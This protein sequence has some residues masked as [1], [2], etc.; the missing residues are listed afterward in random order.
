[1]RAVLL[2]AV[3]FIAVPDREDP[4]AKDAKTLAK[5]LLGAW[6]SVKLTNFGEELDLKLTLVFESDEVRVYHDGKYQADEDARYVID[7][8]KMPAT[9]DI[10]P[11]KPCQKKEQ[12]I[13][14]IEGD[15]MTVCAI[16]VNDGPRPT[17][18]RSPPNS[19]VTLV[20]FK[21]VKK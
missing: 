19:R 8:S 4:A 16:Q 9:M 18:F 1:M 3:L 20:H 21:R 2:L 11:I 14:K 17:E 10:F 12:A 15:Q 7:A 5:Q 13:F 6:E